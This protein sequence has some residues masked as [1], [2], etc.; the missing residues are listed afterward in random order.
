M[1]NTKTEN[2]L[3]EWLSDSKR[4]ADK[5]SE[6]KIGTA[7]T[8]KVVTSKQSTE[9]HNT[10]SII[11][12]KTSSGNDLEDTSI[13]QEQSTLLFDTKLTLNQQN[14]LVNIKQQENELKTAATL[15]QQSEQLNKISNTQHSILH[16]QEE[17]FDALLKLQLEKQTLLE[18]QIKLQQQRINQY[19][20]VRLFEYNIEYLLI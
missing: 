19:I 9:I 4:L 14:S 8:D 17:Q 1:Q 7:K 3:P 13:F 10:N 15:F 2:D 18:K 5:K 12:L 6:T 11:D 20:H 16:S